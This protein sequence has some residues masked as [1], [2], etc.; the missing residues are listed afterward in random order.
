MKNTTR[1]LLLLRVSFCLYQLH[2]SY[3]RDNFLLL[4]DL[5]PRSV[6]VWIQSEWTLWFFYSR[7]CR[8]DVDMMT[9]SRTWQLY[10]LTDFLFK[11]YKPEV[12]F[13]M[14]NWLWFFILFLINIPYFGILIA[15]SSINTT[16]KT[17]QHTISN[18]LV[19]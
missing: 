14:I 2:Q 1:R 6:L 18:S 13:I 7:T 16:T 17:K 9:C 11:W 19:K 5:L 3:L 4:G 10:L 8:Y 15:C 12:K